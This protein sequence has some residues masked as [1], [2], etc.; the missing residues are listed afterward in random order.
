MQD[1]NLPGRTRL[2]PPGVDVDE[3]RPRD[4]DGAAA[5]ASLIERLDA[6]R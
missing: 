2:G 3:F 4:G 5:I 6:E 1:D